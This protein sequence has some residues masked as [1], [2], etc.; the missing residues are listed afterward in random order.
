MANLDRGIFL[1]TGSFEGLHVP[2]PSFGPNYS[3]R[4]AVPGLSSS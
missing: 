2:E 1:N 4:A 3:R